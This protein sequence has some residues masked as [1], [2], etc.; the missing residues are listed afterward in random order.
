[1]QSNSIKEGSIIYIGA[2]RAI[3]SCVY[4]DNRVEVVYTNQ[5][6][7][8]VAEDAIYDN[9]C[10]RF[11]TNSIDATYAERSPRL[12]QYVFMLKNPQK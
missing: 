3:I 9:D 5:S 12:M 10:W 7:R 6:G 8:Y 11:E 2:I 1:M 4:A